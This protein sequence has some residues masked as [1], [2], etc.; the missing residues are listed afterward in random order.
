MFEIRHEQPEDADD[1]HVLH[2]ECFGPDR[3]MRTA[4]RLRRG[5]VPIDELC[6]VARTDAA[7]LG[8]IRMT[9]VHIGAETPAL[10]LGPLAVV[11]ARRGEGIGEALM[12]H[13]LDLAR[14]RGHKLVVLVGDPPYYSRYGFKDAWQLGITTDN[15]IDRDRFLVAE[16][17]PGALKGVVGEV[18]ADAAALVAEP[19]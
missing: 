8:S 17:T 15:P 9:A 5:T 13:A 11:P 1:I 18:R 16:L 10:L 12:R 2:A 19:V 3:H 4:Y 14:W 7:L 6:L